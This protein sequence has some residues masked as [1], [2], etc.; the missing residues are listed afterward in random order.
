M[1][2]IEQAQDIE[3]KSIQYGDADGT[4]QLFLAN[5]GRAGSDEYATVDIYMRYA[6][7]MFAANPTI[8]V[9]SL[10]NPQYISW[11]LL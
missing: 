11:E 3:L 5:I 6:N 7:G 4:G 1:P 8:R 10:K 2:S 9:Q